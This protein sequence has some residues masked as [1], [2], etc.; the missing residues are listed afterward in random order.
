MKQA[1][2]MSAE[3]NSE[4]MD[5]AF[6]LYRESVLPQDISNTQ[7]IETRRAFY[8]GAWALLTEL[9]VMFD[10]GSEPTESDHQKMVS[11]EAELKRFNDRV[12]VGLA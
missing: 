11:I 7:L 4:R 12:R 8:A 1:E 2:G 10:D 6:H 5:R 3:R 9:L